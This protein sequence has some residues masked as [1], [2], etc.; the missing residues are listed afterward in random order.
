MCHLC[1]TGG[2]NIYNHCQR[3]C[4]SRSAE[5][6][7]ST[8]WE[9]SG[10]GGAPDI[11]ETLHI[12]GSGGPPDLPRRATQGAYPGNSNQSPE[13]DGV[14]PTQEGDLQNNLS[15]GPWERTPPGG[16]QPGHCVGDPQSPPLRPGT[17]EMLPLPVVWPSPTR[18]QE[19]SPLLPMQ[20]TSLDKDLSGKEKEERGNCPQVRQL[21]G[22]ARSGFILL[23]S[24]EREGGGNQEEIPGNSHHEEHPANKP[25]TTNKRCEQLPSPPGSNARSTSSSPNPDRSLHRGAGHHDDSNATGE[26]AGN[27]TKVCTDST[28]IN[29]PGRRPRKQA[30][31]CSQGGG[32][33][34][35]SYTQNRP[36]N[37]VGNH[38]PHKDSNIRYT[39]GR[40]D[41]RGKEQA[42]AKTKGWR[43]ILTQQSGQEEAQP[44][45]TQAE[46]G[47]EQT[48]ADQP[49]TRRI[50]AGV[51]D[52]RNSTNGARDI[53]GNGDSSD[54]RPVR[55]ATT[56]R[57]GPRNR[58]MVS[59]VQRLTNRIRAQW[60]PPQL[61]GLPD[62]GEAD[63]V[64]PESNVHIVQWNVR[65]MRT[66]EKKSY[67]LALLKDADPD[68]IL[69]QETNLPEN[70]KYKIPGYQVFN[71][72]GVRGLLSAVKT[73]I[74]AKVD[75]TPVPAGAEVEVQSL[76]VHLSDGPL[77]VI[78]LYRNC[79]EQRG[80]TL[81][82][83]P[84]LRTALRQRSVVAGD[85]NAHH[86]LWEARVTQNRGRTY[87]VGD[88]LAD[89]LDNSEMVILNNG[90][91]T[92][93]SGGSLD[94]TIV[95]P[96]LAP[97]CEWRVSD[98]LVSDHLG[99]HT[100]I[101]LEKAPPPPKPP[102]RLYH[103]ANWEAYR[104]NLDQWCYEFEAPDTL[105][106]ME[107]MVTQAIN[108][109][110][111]LAIPTA[112]SSTP[113]REHWYYG[114][115]VQEMKNRINQHTRLWKH[116][117][118]PA[119]RQRLDAVKDH[120]AQVDQEART[121]KWM[122]WC[123]SF[124]QHTNVSQMWKKL[125]T[126]TGNFC[127]MPTVPNPEHE[128]QN[129]MRDFASRSSTA[130]IPPDTR[131]VLTQLQPQRRQ[132]T[133]RAINTPDLDTDR[134]FTMGELKRALKQT[135]TAP[136]ADRITHQMIYEAGMNTHSIVLDLINRS[137]DERR[138]PSAWKRADILPIPKPKQPGTYR[139]ISLTACP[140]KLAERMVLNRMKWRL[141]RWPARIHGFKRGSGTTDAITDLITTVTTAGNIPCLAVFLDL[142]KA[143]ELANA[144]VITNE[145]AARGI[146]GKLMGWI[147]D[148][149]TGREAR[150]ALQGKHSDYLSLENG[151]PQGAVISPTAFNALMVPIVEMPL[152]PNTTIS[153]Y[154]DDLV[155]LASGDEAGQ[156]IQTAL[157]DLEHTVQSLGL[158]FAPNKTK[159]MAFKAAN[160]RLDLHLTGT[161]IEWVDCF[162]YLGVVL[163]KHLTMR[164][165]TELIASRIRKCNNVM[166]AMTSHTAG[167]TSP[168]LH[169][170]YVAA[171]RPV[172][173]YAACFL[174]LGDPKN[175]IRLDKLQNVALR[176]ILGA[177]G[178]TKIATM[179]E[180][181]GLPP[182]PVRMKQVTAGHAVKILTSPEQT[183]TKTKLLEA[184][185]NPPQDAECLWA[186]TTANILKQNPNN[187]VRLV[188]DPPQGPERPPWVAPPGTF[189]IELPSEGKKAT[190]SQKLLEDAMTRIQHLDLETDVIFYTD[191]SVD[192]TTAK[193]GAGVVTVLQGQPPGAESVQETAL[194]VVDGASTMQTE[195]VAINAALGIATVMEVESLNIHTDSLAALQALQ[196]CSPD[197]NRELISTG[198]NLIQDLEDR[199]TRVVLHWIPSHVDI[200]LNDRADAVAATARSLLRISVNP[201]RSR[202]QLK[203][204]FSVGGDLAWRQTVTALIPT[205]ASV[206]WHRAT[207]EGKP[208]T[209]GP[210][211]PRRSEV[212]IYRLRLGY[213]CGWQIRDPNEA[214]CPECDQNTA[215]PLVHYLV[216][217]PVT[218]P[219]FGDRF[220]L[221]N[222]NSVNLATH[223]VKTACRDLEALARHLRQFP[224]PR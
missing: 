172:M 93:T 88:E 102:R 215:Q 24:E 123:A 41:H 101:A 181:T 12:R 160:P 52:Q 118:T 196:M 209:L 211:V 25:E 163:D 99:I 194:R 203:R 176:L 133:M 82:P 208:I 23:Q 189:I 31:S 21:R 105:D 73:G 39:S 216:E 11:R 33:G 115:R 221:E 34:P 104:N 222:T 150:V 137:Y 146:N 157:A 170:F 128:A 121:E 187:Q 161:A 149:L 152:P 180:E 218:S 201:N 210:R 156:N 8:G 142:E 45:P 20:W 167:A 19:T 61:N 175:L 155:L 165:H 136:G 80:A 200:P 122:E 185:V 74:P 22:E 46:P 159:A 47:D 16:S 86:P 32:S 143:F 26:H 77:L 179:Q 182:I 110:A 220:D 7:H 134:P 207:T 184:V 30:S 9:G 116:H 55:E 132:E 57:H 68:I 15:E 198:Q 90:E 66:A 147:L 95:T 94:L 62:C 14:R 40:S 97:K 153:S 177:P 141:G 219:F 125:K 140:C 114:D 60:E 190:N 202:A 107:E 18:L 84:L 13:D 113:R 212:A 192:P 151:T 117:P 64:P 214:E 119:N 217:C 75:P 126:I 54:N 111:E 178:W 206:A 223:R 103:K 44:N 38:T 205:S 87:R 124:D 174:I 4:R 173:D 186:K 193:A 166:K 28:G 65:G 130:Q 197:D 10:A 96:D 162:Q 83:A 76:Q 85:F 204:D 72:P 59:I 51:N 50:N 138:L 1:P 67:V 6:G 148:F 43:T 191:G 98:T 109:A 129:L 58:R 27:G 5:G 135:N 224:P 63:P 188:E 213:R 131:N 29:G 81:T 139:P 89:A 169:T 112:Q 35:S 144:W 108:I 106:E 36:P 158:K 154:A 37:G 91:P 79:N 92:H 53:S 168:V 70:S 2:E 17:N 78:N 3:H 42:Q 127:R 195:L 100:Y 56:P 145:L 171:V 69:L 183:A 164:Q 49:H 71:Q 199:G 48:N 120:A